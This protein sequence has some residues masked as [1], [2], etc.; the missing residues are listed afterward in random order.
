MASPDRDPS[1]AHERSGRDVEKSILRAEEGTDA[2]GD[3]TLAQSGPSGSSRAERIVDVEETTEGR[4]ER[5][6]EAPAEPLE[7]GPEPRDVGSGGAQRIVGAR[8][9]DRKAGDAPVPDGPP[10]DE[11]AGS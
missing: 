9:P 6:D 8:I 7:R 10:F 1:A 2:Q 4:V 3:H 11:D 5:S